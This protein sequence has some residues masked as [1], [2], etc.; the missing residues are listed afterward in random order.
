MSGGLG[1]SEYV[2]TRLKSYYRSGAGAGLPNAQGMQL[3]LA[4]DA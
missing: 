1:S 2:K 4:E 3:L